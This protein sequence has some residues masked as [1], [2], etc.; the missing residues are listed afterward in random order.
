MPTGY[1]QVKITTQSALPV[2][3]ALV[4]IIDSKTMQVL[5]E[6]TSYTDKNGNTQKFSLDTISRSLTENPDETELP[7][8]NYDIKIEKNGFIFGEIIGVQIFDGVLSI[9]SID[10]LPRPVNY[11]NNYEI[12]LYQGA[13]EQLYAPEPFMQEGID[14]RVLPQVVIPEYITVHLGKPQEDA[15][16]VRVPFVT[17]LKSVA[18]SEIYPT[19]PTESLK[20]NIL[21]QCTFALNRIYTEWYPSKGYNFDITSST[22]YDQKYIHNR[23]TFDST[24][25]IVEEFFDN[26]VA[27]DFAKDPYFTEYCDGK[28]VS[29]NG[30]KQWGTYDRANEG[31]DALEIL[32]FYYGDN[33]EIRE[34]DNIA[35]IPVSYPGTALRRGS[36]G[37]D[38]KIIQSQ[39]NRISD[40]YPALR[41][42]TVDG[43]FGASVEAAVKDF[44]DV[45]NLSADGIVGKAT[46]YKISYIYVSV[47]NLSQL[48]SEGESIQDGSYPGYVVQRGDKGT[49]VLIIQYYINLTSMY[50]GSIYS[51][52]LDGI[53]G[54]GVEE[55]VKNFQRY[56]NL[57]VDGKVG[58]MTWD[59]MFSVYQ[60]IIEGTTT[61]P[62]TPPTND[63]YPGVL[64]R[65]GSS[66]TNVVK[67]Q[68]WINGLS[69]VY[70]TIP[71]LTVDG[72]FGTATQ[73]SVIAFQ[74]R[75]NLAQDGIVGEI[76]WNRMYGEWQNLIADGSIT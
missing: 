1:L 60:S 55:Q 75:F 13:P 53:F 46:W 27:K 16:D 50:V 14:G 5:E 62:I 33:I 7:Y 19:W 44:Q 18:A 37:D 48:T 59:K 49:N 43:I 29:C 66:G 56:F 8:K 71:S 61:P 74:G 64:I 21:A 41:K 45:F 2:Q 12:E 24:D 17:Y 38:V 57:S 76:T 31:L 68:N 34:S 47:K 54:A 25:A 11:G 52:D 28:I 36:T 63:K 15:T 65:V 23:N 73:N 39:L 70:T 9:Q 51:L 40:N 26:Y 6:Y 32:R 69:E 72:K 58:Q 22:S 10:L 30:M 42:L 35:P 4:K 20:A 67:I 3:D